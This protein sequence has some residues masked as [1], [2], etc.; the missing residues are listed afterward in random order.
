VLSELAICHE[1]IWG[2][3]RIDPHFLGLGTNWRWVFSFTPRPLYPPGK[4]PSTHWIRGWVVPRASLDTMEKWKFLTL[5]ELEFWPLSHPVHNRSLYCLHHCGLLIS[6]TSANI[7]QFYIYVLNF[8]LLSL[9]G[10]LKLY[11][12]MHLC[13]QLTH[14][15]QV[16]FKL[17]AFTT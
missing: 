5:P 17:L 10:S 3:G 2:C 16:R 6:K 4:S 7:S 9:D 12:S 15:N 8:L 11:S 13:W 1:D 14:H